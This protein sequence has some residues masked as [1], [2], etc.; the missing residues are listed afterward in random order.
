MYFHPMKFLL[1]FFGCAISIGAQNSGFV[2]PFI[3][4]GGHGHTFPG[5]VLPFGMVQLS[6]DT[7]TDGSWD[8]CSGYHYSDS[9]IYGFSHTHLSGTG[10]S[11][12]GDILLMPMAGKPSLDNK[13]YSSKFSHANEK[14][15]PGFYEVLLNNR[16]KAELTA[17]FRVGIHRY[18]FQG[19][20]TMNLILDL[21]HRDKTLR[22]DWKIRDSVTVVG[23]R[24]SEGWARRQ[25]VY[26]V[27]VFSKPFISGQQLFRD[28]FQLADDSIHRAG[29]AF[30]F[31][32]GDP[33]VVKVAISPTGID[34][35]EKNLMR[36]AAG[37]DFD[38]Y[39]NAAAAKWHTQLQKIEI[40]EWDRDR[41]TVF[42]T[43][44]YHC[45]IHPSVNMD[46]DGKY[47]GVDGKVHSV[48]GFINYSVFSL[49]DTYR[50]LNPLFTIFEKNRT[51]DFISSFMEHYTQSGRLPVWELPG[52]E[53]D[54]MIG[55]HAV[56]VIADAAQKG[57]QGFN[58]EAAYEAM[59]ASSNYS[60]FGIPAFNK[61]GFLEVTD[62][63][64]SV[65]KTL[66]YA[67]DN[68]CVAQVAAKLNRKEEEKEYLKRS[69]GYVNLFDP[70]TGFMRPRTNGTWLQTFYPDEINNHFTE[71][72]SWQYSFYVPHDV[73]GLI[74]L[75]GG[76]AAFEKKLDALFDASSRIRGRQQ[77]DVTGMIGQYA[78]G[79]EPS[80]HMAYL[81]NYVGKPQKT[82][83]KVRQ[84]LNLFYK[85]AP[86]G[87]IGNDDCGQM[88]AWYVLSAIGIYPLCPGNANYTTSEPFFN[89]II[90]NLE[91]GKKF[92]ISREPAT[93]GNLS[94]ITVNG[95]S[96]SRPGISHSMLVN[97]GEMR[98]VYSDSVTNFGAGPSAPVISVS[99]TML[100]APVINASSRVFKDT[101]KISIQSISKNDQSL[102]YAIGEGAWQPYK[103]PFVTDSNCEVR[104]RLINHNDSSAVSVARYYKLKHNYRIG[105]VSKPDPQYSAE[106]A[107]SLIDG[108]TGDTDW[109]K[110]GWIGVQGQDF[111]C[112]VDLGKS[113]SISYVSLHCLQDTRSWI[114]FPK[115]VEFYISGNNKKYE[116]IGTALP[117]AQP[118]NYTVSTGYFSKQLSKP[119][120]GRYLKIVGRNF[121]TLPG[122]HAG[123]G[124][125]AYIFADELEAR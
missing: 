79:N 36:E 5:A 46:V 35:A 27:M 99:S 121:G 109:R 66:E 72:N 103:S 47:R 18:T 76:M 118:D 62:E 86:D 29:G 48:M 57:I 42:Y 64:E 14:A 93:G 2:N 32:A 61:K 84:I 65:S 21:L 70:S 41:R 55:F 122:W 119:G 105:L 25:E 49:W 12:W 68:W 33:L 108:I 20:D 97:G 71:G 11:D 124:G 43:A 39:R 59:K 102:I 24:V 15:S 45:F 111:E 52:N 38:E 31:A 113:K 125:Q 8:G 51:G 78:H 13:K 100:P 91:D 17:T 120:K 56:S 115:Q 16:I 82:I 117:V 44:L 88:S 110:G 83:E 28:T 1:L 54:C 4:T 87:L 69:L 104:A 6:P 96:T 114:V 63:S 3:G 80:Q 19:G 89:H 98:F 53:T 26:F 10:V 34:G 30:K 77:A 94:S 73:N 37:W 50:A 106:G 23:Y 60:A 58:L 67:Y 9:V 112:I 123:S 92:R 7:R 90:L 95:K 85:N 81:Y 75:H 22:C 116:L 74:N 107:Q 40:D 101:L